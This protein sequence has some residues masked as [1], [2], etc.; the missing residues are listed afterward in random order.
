MSQ[1]KP[2]K[3]KIMEIIRVSSKE[4]LYWTVGGSI[5]GVVVYFI[6]GL[7]R[8]PS[9]TYFGLDLGL[10]V[11][12]ITGGVDLPLIWTAIVAVFCGPL[13]GFLTGYFGSLLIDFLI[14]EQIIA[15][16]SINLSIGLAGLIIGIPNYLRDEGFSDGRRLAKLVAYSFLG[17]IVM[18]L[19]LL[20]GYLVIA[21]QSFEGSLLYNILP[22][23]TIWL[24]SL[25]VIGPVIIRIL[26]FLLDI[27]IERIS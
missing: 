7:I 2:L 10:A 26:A 1:E 21:G 23:F 17:F 4:L 13:A 6:L 25:V 20:I 14:F 16:T 24:L 18:F 3:N 9:V 27:L 8:F 11:F 12:P 15:I 19:G 5:I 22:Y